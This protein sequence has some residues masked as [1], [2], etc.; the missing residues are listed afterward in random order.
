[1]YQKK[2]FLSIEKHKHL[3]L[4]GNSQESD[5]KSSV[6]TNLYMHTKWIFKAVFMPSTMRSKNISPMQLLSFLR[7]LYKVTVLT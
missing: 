5:E 4:L 7:L 6:G 2:R 1:M 3:T